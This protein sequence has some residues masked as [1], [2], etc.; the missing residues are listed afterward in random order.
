MPLYAFAG[1]RLGKAA[2]VTSHVVFDANDLILSLVIEIS[3]C[4]CTNTTKIINCKKAKS[5]KMQHANHLRAA[6]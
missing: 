3:A 1:A 5:L 2:L 4:L 6:H